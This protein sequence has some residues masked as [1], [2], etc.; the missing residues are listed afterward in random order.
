[1]A[2]VTQVSLVDDIDGSAASETVSFSLEGRQ[3]QLDLSERNARRLRDAVA[4]FVASARRSGGVRRRSSGGSKMSQ[5]PATDRERTT[6]IREW[7]RQHGHK[8]AD[9]GRIPSS[10]IEAYQKDAG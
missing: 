8:V 6:A 4:P 5:K 2:R 9:R 10:V 7:A 3:Y 1:V